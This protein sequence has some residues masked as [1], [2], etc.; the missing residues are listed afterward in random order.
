M[1]YIKRS[2]TG[3]M[4][5]GAMLM[6]LPATIQAHSIVNTDT[7]SSD[8]TSHKPSQDPIQVKI[9]RYDGDR[10]S[11]ELVVNDDPIAY[12]HIET[13]PSST[14]TWFKNIGFTDC[15]KYKCAYL[16]YLYVKPTQRNKGI[17]K[18]LMQEVKNQICALGY[19]HIHWYAQPFDGSNYN[20]DQPTLMQK[21]IHFYK[22]VGGNPITDSLGAYRFAHYGNNI[23]MPFSMTLLERYS[24]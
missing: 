5:A 24:H 16:S 21:L 23:I 8:K 18:R 11:I 9:T 3:F 7:S 14:Q 17:G 2:I 13:C 22:S 15:S 10:F 1:N 20:I 19:N 6:V 12:A 4:L